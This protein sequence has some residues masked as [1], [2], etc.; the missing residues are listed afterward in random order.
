MRTSVPFSNIQ[1]RLPLK[2]SATAFAN[3]KNFRGEVFWS[4]S[5]SEV[6]VIESLDVG[7]TLRFYVSLENLYELLLLR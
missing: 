6:V 4:F 5:N 1:A 3:F 2:L 7:G